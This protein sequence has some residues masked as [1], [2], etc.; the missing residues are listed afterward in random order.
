MN[1]LTIS[2]ALTMLITLG[3]CS[4]PPLKYYTF[5]ASNENQSLNQINHYSTSTPTI[6]VAPITIPDYLDTTDIVTRHNNNLNHSI[7]GRMSSVLSVAVTDFVTQSLAN[8]NPTLFITN[9]KQIGDF[10]SQILINISRLDIQ[11]QTDKAGFGVLEAN[12]SVV[13]RNEQQPIRKEKGTFIAKGP[14]S[15]DSNVIELEQALLRQL[16]QQIST[17]PL[18]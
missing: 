15:N 8:K 18:Y 17:N 13:P 10:S 14:I 9:Q 12:W 1:K 7:N 4:A 2:A 5:N 16:V 6:I 3:G 11:Q